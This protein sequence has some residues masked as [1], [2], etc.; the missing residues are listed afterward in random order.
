MS[1]KQIVNRTESEAAIFIDHVVAALLMGI[2][3]TDEAIALSINT[4]EHIREKNPGSAKEV[5]DV[6]DA[7]LNFTKS[8]K[9]TEDSEIE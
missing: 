8:I 1:S 4:L 9:N 2:E 7:F 3:M 6:I 5:K